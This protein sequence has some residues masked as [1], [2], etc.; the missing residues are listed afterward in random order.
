[1]ALR[2]FVGLAA[3][4]GALAA[5]SGNAPS[6]S[7]QSEAMEASSNGDQK[8]AI[9]LARK[10]VERFSK[11]DQ[12]SASTNYNCGT[13]ALAY[14]GL[15][16]YQILDGDTAA[17]ESSFNAAKGALARTAEANKASATGIVYRDV[18]EAFW[19]IGD[20]DRAIAVFEEGK[21]AG[22]DTWLFTCSAAKE[23]AEREKK[24]R[25]MMGDAGE[26]MGPPAPTRGPAPVA[27]SG[28]NPPA[29]GA[30][31]PKSAAPPEPMPLSPSPLSV[32]R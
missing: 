12:C 18:S 10:D 6:S 16:E 3:L 27:S 31:P 23:V 9:S 22:G 15:A 24:R 1:M 19:R 17:G 30:N 2:Q 21:A 28:M 11:P 4:A 5:C 13:L 8:K 29:P 20:R 7:N 14:S 25:Q 32:A 26:Q